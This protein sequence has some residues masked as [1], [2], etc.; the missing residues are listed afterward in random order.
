MK[1]IRFPEKKCFVRQTQILY[2]QKNT[3]NF[4]IILIV[5]KERGPPNKPYLYHIC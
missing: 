1:H 4:T 3:L 5:E 2:F